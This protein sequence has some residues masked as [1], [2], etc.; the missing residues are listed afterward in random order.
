MRLDFRRALS[1][2]RPL[3]DCTARS[4]RKPL[5][6]C[7][8]SRRHCS[9]FRQC[10]LKMAITGTNSNKKTNTLLWIKLSTARATRDCY[11]I[12]F[13][14]KLQ[15]CQCLWRLCALCAC[16]II[17]IWRRNDKLWP[18]TAQVLRSALFWDITRRRA[19]IVYWRFGTTYRSRLRGSRVREERRCHQRRGGSLKSRLA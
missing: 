8:M 5:N 3:S 9:S 14:R 7:F 17:H 13:E 11:S 18:Q 19:V 12:D 2:T 15:I 6:F 16:G 1:L 4:F 10:F